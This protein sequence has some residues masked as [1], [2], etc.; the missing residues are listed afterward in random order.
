[1]ARPGVGGGVTEVVVHGSKALVEHP[2][3]AV[4]AEFGRVARQVVGPHLVDGEGD[5]QLRGQV[6]FV[7]RL[8]DLGLGKAGKQGEGGNGEEG[9]EHGRSRIDREVNAGPNLPRGQR[10]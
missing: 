5:N 6:L 3:E 7:V 10:R 8:R 4:L 9:A 1:M 2:A